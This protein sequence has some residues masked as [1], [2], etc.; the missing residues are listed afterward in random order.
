MQYQQGDVLMETVKSIPKECEE[1]QDRGI[2]AYGEV[3]GHKHRLDDT[4]IKTYKDSGGNIYFKVED[5]VKLK[6]EEHNTITVA[7]GIYKS[8]ILREKDWLNGMVRKVVD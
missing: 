1:A 3:T 5:A 2:L 7:P 4:N 6:H 8:W